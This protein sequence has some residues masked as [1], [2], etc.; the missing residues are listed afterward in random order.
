MRVHHLNCTT[1][2]TNLPYPGVT[3]C[4]LIEGEDSLTLVDTGFGIRDYASPS[5]HVELFIR[6]NGIPRDIDE[7]AVSKVTKLGFKP[8][9]IRRIVL[10][11]LH[12]DHVGGVVDFPWGEVHVL[13][14]EFE[15][16][17]NPRK[18]GSSPPAQ[19]KIVGVVCERLEIQV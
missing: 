5:R 11:H 12:L 19:E 15:S 6:V 16:A 8:E 7:T 3:H 4:L 13:K 9:D 10:T 14:T 17:I 18:W 2:H 1:I